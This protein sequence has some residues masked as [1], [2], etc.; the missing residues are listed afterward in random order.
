[1]TGK[2]RAIFVDRDGTLN[3]DKGYTHKLS[4]LKIY[5][6]I[7]P[8]LMDYYEKNFLIIVITNQSGIGR[9][10]Y[11]VDEMESFNREIAKE[12]IFKGIKI[13]DFFYCPHTPDQGC[14][15]RKPETGLIEEA[16]IKYDIDISNSVV[17]GDRES[18]DG[19]MAR[20]LGMKFIK[21]HGY[22]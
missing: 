6:D 18:V 5:D 10:Y 8:L 7:I 2:R 4:D 15:C 16:A 13:E 22:D 20:K 11:T 12:L 1:M 21:V 14:R 9:G 3:Y 19:E 17:I